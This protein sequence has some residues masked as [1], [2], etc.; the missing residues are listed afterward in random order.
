[1]QLI[2][3]VT[4]RYF[5]SVYTLTIDDCKDITV[6]AG[7]NDV[8]K[9]N[10]LKALNL[11]FNQQTDYLQQ[12]NFVDDYSLDRKEEVR[13]DTIRGQQFIS[14]SVRFKRGEMMK[15]SLPPAF[16]VTKKWDMH[17]LDC[18]MSSDVQARMEQHA[19]KK[20]IKYSVKTTTRFLSIF[21]NKIKFIYI[22]AIKDERIFRFALNILQD[23][24]F[25]SKNKP[26]LDAPISAANEAIQTI[27]KEL[28]DDFYNATGIQNSVEIP[29]TLNYAKGLLQI[30]TEVQTEKI[31]GTVSIDKRG[32]G[33]RTHYI[34]KILNYV[35]SQSRNL[36]IWGFEE[37][38]NSY[39]YRRCIQ[40]A[41]EFETCYCRNSQIFLTS[42]S[43]SFFNENPEIKKI[44]IIGYENGRT[45]LLKKN[46]GLDE[47]LGYI[48]LYRHFIDQIK[49]LEIEKKND[50]LKIDE[51]KNTL[52]NITVPT[53]L[54][55]GKTDADLLKIAIKKLGKTKFAT[56]NIQPITCEKTSNNAV[57]LRYLKEV[58]DNQQYM[59]P[60]IGM[61]DRDTKILADPSDELSDIRRKEYVKL[62]KNVYAFA[63]PVPHD[64]CEDDQISIEHYFTDNEIKTE[65]QGKRLFIGNEFYKTG[66]YIGDG[67]YHYK[68]GA[69]V[70][71]TIKIIEHETNA[72]VTNRDGTGDYSI[73]KACFVKS[74]EKEIEGFKDISFSEF[75]KI[76]IVLSNIYEDFTSNNEVKHKRKKYIGETP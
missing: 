51:L 30:N 47:E 18:K 22:P 45:I 73:S 49:Q 69:K 48:E 68:N 3:C 16:T 75:E 55:E 40:V 19:G 61:F 70:T 50:K 24:L 9:S 62:K 5:R 26:I 52:M 41:D 57:L 63:I 6:F 13:K 11:F 43:P 35:A 2:E 12:Y 14:I 46:T 32:D 31:K 23:S 72:C 36:Y 37:P 34:P 33:I 28:Q 76:F 74:I 8:G 71:G 38:E 66:N 39:E 65:L 25:E 53:I 42:H 15:N 56:W 4:I 64:R 21:L 27:I 54:T 29:N 44:N 20:G 59:P 67:P 58:R 1:M 7:K 60:I 17:S 10:I